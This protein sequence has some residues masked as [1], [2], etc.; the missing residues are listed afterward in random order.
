MNYSADRPIESDKDDLL[1]RA[2]FASHL[3]KAICEC[4]AKGGFVIGIYGEWGSGKTSVINMAIHTVEEVYKEESN[5]PIII[6][7]SP[8]NYSE[9]SN[10]ISTFFNSLQNQIAIKGDDEFKKKVGKALSD[11]A[12]AFDALSI[13]P[14]LGPGFAALFKTVAIA[15]GNYLMQE[16]NLDKA[17]MDLEDCLIKLDRKIIVIIDD[18]DRLTNIQIRD[19]FQLVKQVADFSNIIYLLAMDRKIVCRALKEVHNV[20]GNEYLEKIIQVSF[21]IP[22][23]QKVQIN[24]ILLGKLAEIDDGLVCCNKEIDYFRAI[25]HDC[26]EPYIDT[27]R[28]INKVVNTFRFRYGYLREETNYVDLLA[29]TTLEVM[30]PELYK[31]IHNNRETLCSG[32]TY[33]SKGIIKNTTD[34][35]KHYKG[36]FENISV[37]PEITI[38]CLST[39]FPAFEAALNGEREAAYSIDYIR[40]RQRIAHYEKFEIYFA[41]N[42]SVIKVTRAEI[43]LF[44]NNLEYSDLWMEVEDIY[45]RGDIDCFFDELGPLVD[46]IPEHRLNLIASVLLRLLNKIGG[47]S[48]S[49]KSVEVY[50][51]KVGSILIEVLN[52]VD[53]DENRCNIIVRGIELF[54]ICGFGALSV[55]IDEMVPIEGEF[56]DEG[57]NTNIYKSVIN[58][59]DLGIIKN[60]YVEKLEGWSD[61]E[62]LLKMNMFGQAYYLWRRIDYLSAEI[63]MRKLLRKN[64]V[65]SLR[66]ICA[67]ANE[68]TATNGE[69]WW[70]SQESYSD[71]ILPNVVYD[72]ID[73]FDKNQMTTFSRTELLKL[74]SFYLNYSRDEMYKADKDEARELVDEWLSY[75]Q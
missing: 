10:L 69:G 39:L 59:D 52:R 65:N 21:E 15:K 70:F 31:W 8:W 49:T 6:K 33:G 3:G 20:E 26:I 36:E 66:F 53:C 38:R 64:I 11:Y 43:D 14:V 18:I 19:V 25:R 62:E 35:E 16:V 5:K 72:Y 41:F 58:R 73:K 44:M 56:R 48:K 55:V 7:F 63:H 71:L 24:E 13:I 47:D 51:E 45:L 37:N 67:I 34:L 50:S 17:R 32:M 30:E 74:A 28:D 12:G 27:V 46:E 2:S 42:L 61:S 75:P 23:L 57:R 1:E 29:I 68:W 54:D 9:Q 4:D 22:P 40:G 60:K